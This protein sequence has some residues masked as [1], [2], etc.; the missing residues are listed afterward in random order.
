MVTQF[1]SPAHRALGCAAP[2]SHPPHRCTDNDA[3]AVLVFYL[4]KTGI[5]GARRTIKY[6]VDISHAG[7]TRRGPTTFR[8]KSPAEAG[9]MQ[10]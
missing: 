9:L 5:F 2:S 4:D 8:K 3:F 1:A 10:N 6:D 7:L